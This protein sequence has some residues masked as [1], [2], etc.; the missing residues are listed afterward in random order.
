MAGLFVAALLVAALLTGAVLA[1]RAAY[2]S[3]FWDGVLWERERG[4]RT[5]KYVPEDLRRPGSESLYPSKPGEDWHG[6]ESLSAGA[7]ARESEG[8]K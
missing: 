7:I 2:R 1:N 6:W 8:P 4:G 3:G 5:L